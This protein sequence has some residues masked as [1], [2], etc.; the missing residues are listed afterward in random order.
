MKCT[1]F[2]QE[3]VVK[4]HTI[5]PIEGIKYIFFKARDVS[6]WRDV[7]DSLVLEV[8]G[9]PIV[10]CSIQVA[11]YIQK[12]IPKIASGLIISNTSPE[13]QIG[14]STIFDWNQYSTNIPS[15]I[16]LN[17]NG[18]IHKFGDLDKD[19]V[20]LPTE[21]FIRPVS[22]WKP[23]AGFSCSRENLKYEIKSLFQLEHVMPHELSVVFPKK[24]I[25]NEYRYWIVDGQISTSSSYSW[26]ENKAHTT[27]PCDADNFV[28]KKVLQYFDAI[29]MMD[30]VL[31]IAQTDEGYKVIEINA[32]STSGWYGAMDSQKLL[33][34]VFKLY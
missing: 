9:N 21:M 5:E 34:D 11:R 16:L 26:D 7:V 13:P 15:E 22:G 30:F 33:T 28:V 3:E 1:F 6:N 18:V 32:L 8:S 2:L 14:M 23:F 17:S 20:E 24:T 12:N 27:T 10:F 4:R 29:G 19:W 25:L 31:D